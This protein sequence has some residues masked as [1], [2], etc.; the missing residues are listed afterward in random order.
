MNIGTIFALVQYIIPTIKTVEG[1]FR[2]RGRGDS[3]KEAV[4]NGVLSHLD[5]LV[6][7]SKDLPNI[8]R[9]Q[10]QEVLAN[11][12][13]LIKLIGDLID[14]IVA[15]INFFSKLDDEDAPGDES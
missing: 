7:A 1:L 2:G 4:T 12:P 9:I 5:E 11:S 6:E 3:K 15:L 13:E 8:K 14:A 10:W